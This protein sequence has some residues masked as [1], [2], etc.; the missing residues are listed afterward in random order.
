MKFI[1]SR[2]SI[3]SIRRCP[4]SEIDW[5]LKSDMHTRSFQGIIISAT[6]ASAIIV[7]LLVANLDPYD[8]H[9]AWV[10]PKIASCLLSARETLATGLIASGGALWELRSRPAQPPA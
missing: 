5:P 10:F 2:K 1:N 6:I 9:C 4:V 7:I 8:R 3:S